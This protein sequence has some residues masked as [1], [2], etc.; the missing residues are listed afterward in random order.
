VNITLIYRAKQLGFFS[1]EKVFDTIKGAFPESVKENTLYVK[2]KGLK[3][4]NLFFLRRAILK[5]GRGQIYHVTGD[6]HYAVFALPRRR[7]VLTIH[8]SVFLT[9]SK[10][11]KRWVLKK[12]FLDWPIWYV[13]IVTVIS[14]KTKQEIVDLS[15]CNSK[16]VRVINN[17]ISDSIYYSDKEFNDVKPVFLFVGSTPNKNLDRV[18]ESLKNVYCFLNIVGKPTDI[19]LG[20]MKDAGI[21]FSVENGLSDWEMA[22]RYANADVVLFPSLYEGFGLPILE[23]FKAGRAV[24]TS[25]ISPMNELAEDAAWLV[26]P[27]DISS[28]TLTLKSILTSKEEREER[29]RKGL[30][31][32]KKYTPRAIADQYISVYQELIEQIN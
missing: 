2:G 19:Q 28:I 3:L 8:D 12:V 17:P 13:P 32:A 15:G 11:I 6:I 5:D 26:D 16:K 4:S 22:K 30:D 14:E 24:L 31:I 27:F 7:S 9:R 23:G 29:I 10:G 1:I 21:E 18:I 25:A 20:R